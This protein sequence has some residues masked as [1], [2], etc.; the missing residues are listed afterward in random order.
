MPEISKQERIIKEMI[1]DVLATM[2]TRRAEMFHFKSLVAEFLECAR[3]FQI[4]LLRRDSLKKLLLR[5]VVKKA[6][7]GGELCILAHRFVLK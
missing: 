3:L 2:V 6:P 5:G 1:W 7:I 4:K